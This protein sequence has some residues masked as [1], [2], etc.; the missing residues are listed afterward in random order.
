[1]APYFPQGHIIFVDP[2]VVAISGKKV[3]AMLSDSNEATFKQY[4]EDGG[5]KMLKAMNPNWPEPYI[6]ING[7]CRIV[8]TVIFAGAE[9]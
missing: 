5:Q 2:E 6:A 9:T 4:I 1:M 8:G 3:V 7:N